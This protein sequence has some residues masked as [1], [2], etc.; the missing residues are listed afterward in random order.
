MVSFTP[1]THLPLFTTNTHTHTHI[2][3]PHHIFEL[4]NAPWSSRSTFRRSSERQR[5]TPCAC[6]TRGGTQADLRKSP[7]RSQGSAAARTV[8]ERG[9]GE[10]ENGVRGRGG[11]YTREDTTV[12]D[13]C[14]D[15]TQLCITRIQCAA[16]R[17][18]QYPTV[19]SPG[20]CAPA[21]C[22]RRRCPSRCS[23]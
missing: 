13:A 7:G 5:P 6:A 21:T 16:H 20:S 8:E 10:G 19:Y 3:T 23:L 14:R 17:R 18:F 22:L 2:P 15:T 12:K 1:S 4:V 9:R 11:R